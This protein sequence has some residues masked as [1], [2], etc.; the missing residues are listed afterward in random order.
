M[1]K[2]PKLHIKKVA[3]IGLGY[4]GLPTFVAI[5]KTN[6]YDV[7]GFDIAKEKIQQLKKGISPII[8]TD[9][10][11]YINKH[12]ISVS[13]DTVILE[14]SDV[15]IIC[16]P[17][18]VYNDYSPNY[19][20]IIN[21]VK[22]I[23]PYLKKGTHIVLE[24]TVNPGTCKEVIAPI[25]KTR[26]DLT[27]GKDL[28]LAHCPERINPGDSRWTIYNIPRNIGSINTQMNR[29]IAT[30]YRAFITDAPINEV[31]SLEVAESTKIVENTFRDIN[32]AFVNELAKSFDA[33]GIDLHE[34]LTAAAN[35]PFGY[36]AHWPGCGVGGHCIAIDPY[37]LIS[38]AQKSGFNHQF[39]KLARE[40]NN[41]MPE[42]TIEKILYTLNEKKLSINGTYITLLGLSYKPN[43]GD[44]RE[45]PALILEKR[46]LELGAKLTSYDP[47][48]QNDVKSLKEAVC[49]AAVIVIATAHQEFITKLP[50]LLKN[51]TVKIIVDGR[52]CLNKIEIER[53]GILYK[54]IGR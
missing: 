21:A 3:I 15:F 18:P 22:T 51:S 43:I 19:S 38:Q 11:Q 44:M 36:L 4:T 16:V 23:V 50:R 10:T 31:S 26:S 24:S 37:Y 13:H 8:D 45:S 9:V 53:L 5:A 39:L 49:K 14:N 42:Y 32:V 1:N 40:I 48:T 34:T 33:M 27:L 12:K 2:T 46:L 41:S 6:L 54:G 35:K 28:N 17:T 25:L 52:N 20:Y 7:V 47:F 30:F 29:T